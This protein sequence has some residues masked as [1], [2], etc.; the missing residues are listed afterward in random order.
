MYLSRWILS[1][2]IITCTS[3][4][5]KKKKKFLPS[6]PCSN[7]QSNSKNFT[8][9]S[10]LTITIAGYGSVICQNVYKRIPRIIAAVYVASGSLRCIPG[11][12]VLTRAPP[13][14][15]SYYRTSTLAR[16][17]STSGQTR[18]VASTYQLVPQSTPSCLH[19]CQ[20]N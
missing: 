19:F 3:R 1:Y 12:R 14:C 13:A 7:W 4:P 11:V 10:L 15:C 16:R 8:L 20:R 17:P 5:E 2:I 9:S 6:L 18:L